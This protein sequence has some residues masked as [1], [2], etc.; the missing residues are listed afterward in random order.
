MSSPISSSTAAQD[1]YRNQ[2]VNSRN[3]RSMNA[4]SNSLKAA[5]KMASAI[6]ADTTG[7][8]NAQQQVSRATSTTGDNSSTKV[9]LSADGVAKQQAEST[10]ST[11][12]TARPER[13]Q[14]ASV[15][16]AIAYGTARAA[17]QRGVQQNSAN[18]EENTRT[19]ASKGTSRRQFASVDEA[20][21]YGTARAAEQTAA[22]QTSATNEESS[23]AQSS[24]NSSSRRQFASV[25]D[26]IS[27]GTQRALEQYNKQR[28][29]LG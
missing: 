29:A 15:D 2:A 27:Y 4:L 1:A 12:A 7:L 22:R 26:A 19:Q 28:T 25:E 5:E 23:K 14:F 9:T 21:A 17:E 8:K 16:E 11:S 6:G 10:R 24:N 3:E 18:N 20:I 13:R